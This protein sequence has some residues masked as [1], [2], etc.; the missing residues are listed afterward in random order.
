[1][2]LIDCPECGRPISTEAEFCPQCGHPNQP[3]ALVPA[4]PKCYAC[5]AYAT[6]RCQKC[7]KPSCTIHVGSVYVRPHQVDLFE[8]EPGG[9]QLRCA[10]CEE[11]AERDIRMTTLV[12]VLIIAVA[13]MVL[14]VALVWR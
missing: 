3:V 1:M 10:G 6:T 14:I 13:V 5:P 7:N 11:E 4:G 2:P 9:H 8:V 12:I